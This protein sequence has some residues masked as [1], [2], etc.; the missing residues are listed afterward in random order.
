[1][2]KIV[3]TELAYKNPEIGKINDFIRV[4]NPR[5]NLFLN[6]LTSFYANKPILLGDSI[7][8]NE[9]EVREKKEKYYKR[10]CC[11][12]I[13]TCSIVCRRRQ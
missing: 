6:T 11:K 3:S 9:P 5:Y 2:N 1:M 13:E 10:A 12:I 7:L 8:L 4:L